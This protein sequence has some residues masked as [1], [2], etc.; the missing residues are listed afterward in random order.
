MPENVKRGSFG[1]KFGVIAATA[2]SAVGLGNIWRFPYIAGEN[3]GGA[4]LL[5]YLGFIILIGLPVMLSELTIGRSTQ[6]NPFGA[7]R[8]L[9]PGQ[10]WFWIGVMGIAAAFMINAFYSVVA[11]WT[12]EYLFKAI[13]NQFTGESPE[14]IISQFN[15]FQN[16][17]WRPLFWTVLFLCISGSVVWAGIEKGIEKYTKILMPVLIVLIVILD[18]RAIT[19]PGAAEGL[20]F[21]FE[22]DFSKI[23][24]STVLEALG[25]AFFSLSIGMGTL[26]TYGSYIKKNENL[27]MSTAAVAIIDTL[28]AIMAG[29]AIFPA[30]FAFGISPAS[31]PDLVFLTLP[32]IF[33]QMKGGYIFALFFFTLL[34]VAALTSTISILEVVVAYFTE[35]LHITRGRA[36]LLASLGIGFLG[37]LS[38]LSLYHIPELSIVGRNLFGIL[39]FISS[40]VL[41]P[42]G[43]LLIVIFVAWLFGK[44]K[45]KG[46]LSSNGL[47]KA[48]YFPIF[49]FIVRYVAPLAIA[50]V[51]MNSVGLIKF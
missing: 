18:I 41:L 11:G 12:L 13:T 35:E 14:S 47:F 21:L 31:G 29:V 22:P 44:T 50:L 4:F 9:R 49:L 20:R 6:R 17:N 28:I 16:S 26:I 5:L 1:S 7:F 10:K 19:L 48:S 51:L 37:I 45:L 38:S 24:A 8:L 39:E 15:D 32:N 42:L 3:G 23:K 25:Q 36:T 30:V 34:T 2:G 43:G 40:N 33:A 27:G 46:E